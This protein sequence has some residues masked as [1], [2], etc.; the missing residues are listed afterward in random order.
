MGRTAKDARDSAAP[1]ENAEMT[2]DQSLGEML[3]DA[4]SE[5]TGPAHGALN[6]I[7]IALIELKHRVVSVEP[8]LGD[9]YAPILER[10]KAL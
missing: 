6:A 10:I 3:A 1:E 8:H 2:V 7:S 9:E 5:T 4:L